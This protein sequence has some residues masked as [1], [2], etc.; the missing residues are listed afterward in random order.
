MTANETFV[1]VGAFVLLIWS[2]VLIGCS[3]SL[4]ASWNELDRKR[5]RLYRDIAAYRRQQTR[6]TF[7]RE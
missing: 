6:G 5:A 4:L 3:C 1:V 7:E 2:V